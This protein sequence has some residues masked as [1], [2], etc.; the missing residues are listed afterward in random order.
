MKFEFFALCTCVNPK[1]DVYMIVVRFLDMRTTVTGRVAVRPRPSLPC[2][3]QITRCIT[4][5]VMQAAPQVR[6]QGLW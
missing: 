6:G 5:P 3:A 2:A 1:T 4:P